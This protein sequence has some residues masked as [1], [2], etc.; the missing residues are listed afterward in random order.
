MVDRK[1]RVVMSEFW[2]Q[3]RALNSAIGEGITLVTVEMTNGQLSNSRRW[4]TVV[5]YGNVYTGGDSLWRGIVW[6]RVHGLG[7]IFYLHTL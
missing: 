3:W 4:C 1:Q 2:W 6:G 7:L 5:H